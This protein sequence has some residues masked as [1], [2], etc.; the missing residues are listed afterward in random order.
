MPMR[1][2]RTDAER[3]ESY[4]RLTLAGC[5]LLIIAYLLV[6]QLILRVP[7]LDEPWDWA[8]VFTV[9][10]TVDEPWDAE[11]WEQTP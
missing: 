6:L 7:V 2:K 3:Y 9:P 1:S 10:E 8:D 5:A 4:W 11:L